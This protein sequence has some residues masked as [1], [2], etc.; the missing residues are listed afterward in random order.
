MT[1]QLVGTAAPESLEL[2]NLPAVVGQA[3]GSEALVAA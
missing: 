3:S 1:V 2:K